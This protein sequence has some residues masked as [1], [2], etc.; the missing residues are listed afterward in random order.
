MAVRPAASAWVLAQRVERDTRRRATDEAGRLS[1]RIIDAFLDSEY[2]ETAVQRVLASPGGERL[3]AEALESPGAARLV[4][5]TLESPGAERL[6]TGALE[7]P[8]AARLV[9]AALESPGVERILMQ[10]VESR[11]V[12]EAIGRVA[13]DAVDRLRRSQAMWTLVD[14]IVQSPV[15]TDAIAQQGVGFADQVGEEIRDRSRHADATLERA[16]W[17][18]LR[19]RGGGA[20]SPGPA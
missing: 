19:R 14:E 7:S 9:A 10:I 20:P 12:D 4:A 3:L 15:V 8:G 6:L 11:V 2:A 18:L 13:E 1:L 5:A 17:R 16:A